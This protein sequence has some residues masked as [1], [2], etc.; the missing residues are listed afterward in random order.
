MD[1]K[2]AAWCAALIMAIGVLCLSHGE[3]QTYVDAPQKKKKVHIVM[4]S[5]PN[6]VEQFAGLAADINEMYARRHGYSFSHQ[7]ED[8]EPWDRASMVWKMVDVI[9]EGLKRDDVDAVFYIDSDAVFYR[10]QQSLDWLF[11]IPGEIIGCSDVPNGPNYINTGTLFVRNTPTAKNLIKK[12]KAMRWHPKYQEFPYEQLA[13]EDLAKTEKQITALPAKEFN[14]VIAEV[15]AGQR[16]TF[17]LHLMATSA[18]DRRT[19]F[20]AIR[21]KLLLQ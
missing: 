3:K 13:L 10:Q 8:M 5:T 7:I 19:E 14:S 9:E 11:D 4:F 16:D 15:Y 17:V 18:E 12:W 2:R 1:M 20:Q 21:Q 6:I